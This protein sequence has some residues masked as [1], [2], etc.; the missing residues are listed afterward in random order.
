MRKHLITTTIIAVLSCGIASAQQAPNSGANMTPNATSGGGSPTGAAGGGLTGTYPNP[1]VAT[2]PASAL[3][4]LTGDCTTTAG[5]VA[6]TCT[7]TNG[8]AF[9]TGATTPITFG[10]WTPGIAFGGATTGITYTLQQGRYAQFGTGTNSMVCVSG[11]V[12]TS[13]KGS[14]TGA[15]TITGF[16]VASQ[17]TAQNMTIINTAGLTVSGL[18]VSLASAGTT[19]QVFSMS[20]GVNTNLSNSSAANATDF[21]ISGCY[22]SN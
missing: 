12:L 19:G 13:S 21:Q 3:P 11:Y 4:A 1:T 9:A 22:F 10:S 5:T 7:K 2:V 14:A 6:T 18:G 15:L 17:V 16:P 8:T 20:A